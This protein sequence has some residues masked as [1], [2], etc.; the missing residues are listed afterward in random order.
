MT[1][2][3]QIEIAETQRFRLDCALYSY[4][5]ERRARALE[6]LGADPA[7]GRPYV[8]N[9]ALWLWS[10]DG[11]DFIYAVSGDFSRL[12]LLE[13]RPQSLRQGKMLDRIFTTIDRI[14]AIKRLFG[15]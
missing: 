11:F 12:V 15:F 7:I 3:L 9:T 5:G 6:I 13:L 2:I 8:E 14:N 4:E 10:F 1:S